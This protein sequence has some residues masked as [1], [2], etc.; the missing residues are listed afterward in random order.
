LLRIKS[1]QLHIGAYSV[2]VN[3]ETWRS[4]FRQSFTSLT[5]GRGVSK[6]I[7][8]GKSVC[9]CSRGRLQP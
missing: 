8:H 4:F 3:N 7:F 9:A 6:Q 1:A 2:T 5:T